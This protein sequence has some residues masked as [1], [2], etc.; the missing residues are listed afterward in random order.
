MQT[1]SAPYQA[2]YQQDAYYLVPLAWPARDLRALRQDVCDLLLYHTY[3]GDVIYDDDELP[4]SWAY[5]RDA[6]GQ[7]PKL[8]HRTSYVEE[9]NGLIDDGLLAEGDPHD[10]TQFAGTAKARH[11]LSIGLKYAWTDWPPPQPWIYRPRAYLELRWPLWLGRRDPSSRVALLA[12]LA[13]T[14]AT[15]KVMRGSATGVIFLA[16]IQDLVIAELNGAD[17]D[18]KIAVN[19]RKGLKELYCLGLIDEGDAY[20]SWRF[21]PVRLESLPTWP[22]EPLAA[23]LALQK[24]YHA[25]LLT[26]MRELLVVCREPV[27]ALSG[28]KKMVHQEYRSLIFSNVEA[29]MLREHLRQQHNTE[30]IPTRREVMDDF[31]RKTARQ[32]ESIDGPAFHCKA[33]LMMMIDAD[34]KGEE[35]VMPVK[36]AY[37]LNATQIRVECDFPAD[38]PV[39]EVRAILE[40][41][42]LYCWQSDDEQSGRTIRIPIPPL[43]DKS[44]RYGFVL[45]AN[46]LHKAL[47]YSR[48]FRFLL[49]CSQP[50][51]KVTLRCT[52]RVLRDRPASKKVVGSPARSRG[53]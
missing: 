6:A 18:K 33:N 3:D 43:N 30:R 5:E 17:P 1:S 2:E 53:D 16:D 23:A 38:I 12:L 19:L 44:I 22:L 31:R 15:S 46:H 24:S 25:P 13:L 52:L 14:Q 35:L 48:P 32:G 37:Q 39:K 41:A 7:W 45:S 42:D 8:M 47:D 20:E 28:L 26:L 50:N 21:D 49:H 36:S 34:E 29:A 11:E 40:T 4:E 51:A 27:N 10:L 9:K